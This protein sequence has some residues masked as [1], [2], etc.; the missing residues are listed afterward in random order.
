MKELKKEK[1]KAIR[2]YSFKTEYEMRIERYELSEDWDITGLFSGTK[3]ELLQKNEE[4]C[5]G[6]IPIYLKN[7]FTDRQGKTIPTYKNYNGL[8]WFETAKESL[9]S[10][11]EVEEEFV[12]ITEEKI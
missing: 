2:L 7:F 12:I 3:Q 6:I 5:K 9:I 4:W 8:F 10:A 1:D 11:L